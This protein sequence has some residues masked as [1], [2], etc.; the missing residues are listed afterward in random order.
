MLCSMYSQASASATRGTV[1]LDVLDC[2]PCLFLLCRHCRLCHFTNHHSIQRV[3]PQEDARLT[4]EL[5]VGG[6][7]GKDPLL[8][9][10]PRGLNCAMGEKLP[11]GDSKVGDGGK[12]G[13]S[14]RPATGLGDLRHG[15]LWASAT[16]EQHSWSASNGETLS[17]G[18]TRPSKVIWTSWQAD[19]CSSASWVLRQHLSG[20][21]SSMGEPRPPSVG[22]AASGDPSC[23]ASSAS[24][25]LAISMPA[26]GRFSEQ[27]VGDEPAQSTCSYATALVHLHASP[28]SGCDPPGVALESARLA[29]LQAGL[30]GSP[31]GMTRLRP[32]G[33]VLPPP[34]EEASSNAAAPGEGGP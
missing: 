24:T 3:L 11:S 26:C 34:S 22:A 25:P 17:K 12:M 2:I 27:T 6:R 30:P 14:T 18:E 5:A 28:K 1:L 32:R 33:P 16:A 15:S 29:P 19:E 23:A 10:A 31:P 9:R 21:E 13:E 20:D 8:P 4:A 7:P